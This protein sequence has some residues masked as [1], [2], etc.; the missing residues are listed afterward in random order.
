MGRRGRVTDHYRLLQV[1]R[2]ASPEVIA[3]AYRRLMRD[4]HPDLGGDVEV[5]RRLNDA[6]ET[7]ADPRRREDYDRSLSLEVVD[8]VDTRAVENAAFAA[9]RAVGRAAAQAR[10]V[11]RETREDI[12]L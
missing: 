11:L 5:A 10:G 8:D 9:G 6:Y 3:A 12:G 2:D 7:L 1:R 4:A